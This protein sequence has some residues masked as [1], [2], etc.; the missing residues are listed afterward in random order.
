MVGNVKQGKVRKEEAARGGIG[1]NG[2][3]PAQ[4]VEVR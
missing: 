4:N 3:L 1:S 2:K